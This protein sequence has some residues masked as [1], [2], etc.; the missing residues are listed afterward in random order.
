MNNPAVAPTSVDFACIGL[1]GVFY[2]N[3]NAN[4]AGFPELK[5]VNFVVGICVGR[6]AIDDH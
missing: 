6:A 3:D 1:S 4:H 2:F 5:E